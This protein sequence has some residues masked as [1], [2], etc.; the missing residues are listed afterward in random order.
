[1]TKSIIIV[2][3]K[4]LGVLDKKLRLSVNWKYAMVTKNVMH[5]LHFKKKVYFEKI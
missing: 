5:I 4:T 1:M 2:T 3:F